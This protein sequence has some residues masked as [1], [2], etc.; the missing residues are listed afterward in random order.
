ML[1]EAA[2]LLF[3]YTKI[4]IDRLHYHFVVI[5]CFDHLKHFITC[6]V[7]TIMLCNRGE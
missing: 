4:Y 3:T 7:V 1:C 5:S 2:V 6:V